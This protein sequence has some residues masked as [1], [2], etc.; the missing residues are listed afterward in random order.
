[1]C[2]ITGYYGGFDEA[3]LREMTDI[4][5]HRGPDDAGIVMI[6]EQPVGLGHRRLSIIDLSKNGQQPMWDATDTVLIT[7]NGEIYNYREL[8][9]QL[10][11]RGYRFRSTSDTEVL[12]NLYLDVGLEML[13]R[14]NGIFAFAIWDSRSKDLI[15]ARDG[16]GV[17]PLYFSQTERGFLFASELKALLLS[18]DVDRSIDRAAVYHY[19]TYLYCPSP[20]TI[21]SDVKKI[22]PGHAMIVREGTLH[23]QFQ[24]YELPYDQEIDQ[25]DD[26]EAANQLK[27]RLQIAVRRQLVADVEVGAFLSG[28]LDSSSVVAMAKEAMPEQRMS[29]FT[30]R[31]RGEDPAL[32]REMGTDLPYAER[33][34]EQLGVNLHHID[35]GPDLIDHL[36]TMIYHLDEP[37]GDVA[38]LNVYLICQLAREHGIKVLLSGAGGDDI[39]GGYRRHYALSLE[40]YWAWL[41]RPI[42][43]GMRSLAE[44]TSVS[45]NAG[46]RFSRAFLYADANPDLRLSSYFRWA[47]HEVIE[48]LFNPE[49]RDELTRLRSHTFVDDALLG[50]DGN[51]SSLNKM[52]YLDGKFFLTD[53]NLN[54]TDKMSMSVGVETRVPLL[55]P[56]LFAF[57]ARLPPQMKQRGSVG[58]W[59]FKKTMEEYLPRE[60]IYRPKVG[61][62]APLIYWL[63]HQ[64]RPV[65]DDVLSHDTLTK[66]GLFD[67]E[68]VQRLLEMNRARRVEASYTIFTLICIEMWCRLFVDSQNVCR[69][70]V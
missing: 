65:A 61:F 44:N 60:V 23:K 14:L 41:P 59:L 37:Q 22:Q 52:L 4:V 13:S 35:V 69:P 16:V 30:I 5:A 62:G 3:L 63:Q 34:A 66:R 64:L 2:G 48:S 25:L 68:G 1:M 8:R 19:L 31:F 9:S 28:G 6:P 38:P 45:S 42:R 43:R 39:L 54:Y 70:N 11:S 53:H 17:K 55:D 24:F 67:P 56:D 27:E 57:A 15:L 20:H 29:C 21:L 7:Y 33:V 47:R 40:K 49:V 58:K 18:P 50:L 51:I 10:E 36:E 12:L 46:R 32:L 26:E